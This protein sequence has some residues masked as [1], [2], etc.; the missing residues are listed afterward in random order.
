MRQAVL[1]TSEVA[2]G[3]HEI[4]TI[5]HPGGRRSNRS[6]HEFVKNGHTIFVDGNSALAG[7]YYSV[8]EGLKNGEPPAS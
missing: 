7:I 3:G 6:G 5:P 4:E 1:L 2:T 8:L